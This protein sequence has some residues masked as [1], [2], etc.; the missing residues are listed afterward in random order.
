MINPGRIRVLKK[1]MFFGKS[2]L[3]WM[4][5]DK[6]VS[7]NWALLSAQ[8][9]AIDN[10]VPLIVCFQYIG[11]FPKS[12]IRQYGFL[13]KGLQET[14][15]ALDAL[16]IKFY[17]LQGNADL[18]LPELIDKQS[19]GAIVVDYSPLKV[20]RR[21]LKRV[22]EKVDIPIYQVDSHNIVPCWVSSYKKEYAA[23]TIR[24]KIQLNL[25]S[26][27]TDIP[28]AIYHPYNHVKTDKVEWKKIID[29]LNIDHTIHEIDWAKS[30]EKAAKERLEFLKTGLQMYSLKRNN[31]TLK[32]L[33]NLSPYFHF[34]HISPQ[35]VAWEIKKSA[36]PKIDKESFLEELIIRRELADNFCEYE[37]N[38]DFFEGFHPW[39]QKSLNEHR[40]DEREYLYSLGHFEAAETHDPLWNAAQNQMKSTGK[41]HG[42]MRMYWAKKILEWSPSPEDALQTAIELNDKYELDGRDPNGYSGIAWSIG[43]IHDR[44]WFDRPVFGKI[45]YMNY[46]GCKS[47]FDI[48]KYIEMYTI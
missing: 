33:S 4:N 34:G 22:I 10:N 38:Y 27:L 20:Y 19:V 21:R 48:K 45:R 6:R 24:K 17:L 7:D 35:R 9:I 40:N 44:A 43:G 42:Y 12:N 5:R 29:R 23:Y 15:I 32:G 14:E 2:V 1:G 13:F 39:A 31:P 16:N 3:Y 26:Y 41:M 28:Q 8:K 37:P 18:V 25:D 47:K 36:L 30:G 11:N 46:N